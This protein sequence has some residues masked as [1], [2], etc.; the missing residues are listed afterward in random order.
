MDFT[1]TNINEDKAKDAGIV[2]IQAVNIPFAN[3]HLTAVGLSLAP[4]P[5]TDEFIICVPLVG[6]PKTAAVITINSDDI[7]ALNE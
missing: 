5:S 2:I 4:T 7:C 1:I 6:K 3:C